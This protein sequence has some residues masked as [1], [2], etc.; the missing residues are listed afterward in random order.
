MQIA[1]ALDAAHGAG[2]VHRDIKPD[3]VMVRRDG[4]VKVLDFGIA[5]LTAAD[6]GEIDYEGETLVQVQTRV[7]MILGTV[8]YMSPEQ[9]RG[10]ADGCAHRYLEFWLRAL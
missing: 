3:N 5:K 9:A 10:K 2:I 6:T 4:I 8:A 1:S 7:G